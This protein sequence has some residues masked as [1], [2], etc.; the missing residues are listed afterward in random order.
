MFFRV[1]PKKS[2][3]GMVFY[4]IIANIA[5]FILQ[6]TISGFTV[7]FELVPKEAMSGAFWQFVTYMFLHGDIGHIFWNMLALFIFGTILERHMGSDRFFKLYFGAG[8][9]SAFF[10][11]V[12][13]YSG[14]IPP[15]VVGSYIISAVNIPMLG[16]SGAVFGIVT[17]FAFVFP[18]VPLIIFPIP[19]PIKAKYAV[20]GFIAFSLLAGFTGVMPG[21]G[22]FG[23]LGGIIAGLGIMLYW[24]YTERSRRAPE[25]HGLEFAWE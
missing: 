3:R 16:A 25:F 6:L 5:I 12:L 11:I 17:A 8:M 1:S 14:I 23:H 21:I 7:F 22:H 24:R 10:H 13:A 18:D 15:T 9:F 19:L 2:G 20:M 4:L